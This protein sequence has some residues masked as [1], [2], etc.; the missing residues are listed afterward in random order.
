MS[1][2]ERNNKPDDKVTNISEEKKL[3]N[4]VEVVVKKKIIPLINYKINPLLSSSILNYLAIGINLAI[5]GCVKKEFFKLHLHKEFYSKYYLVSGIFLYI[6]GL[7]DWYDGKEL[8]YLVDFILSFFFVSLFFFENRN[9]ELNCFKFFKIFNE[10]GENE[11]LHGTFYILLFLFFFCIAIS[12]KN[13]G[14]FYIVDH[15]SLF[16]GFIFLFLHKYFDKTWL[17][18]T[19]SYIFIISGGLFWLTGLLKM[20]DNFLIN[21]SLIFLYPSD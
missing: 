12:Y 3:K 7:F 5:F 15:A 8:L 21:N 4:D 17:L 9:E 11:K 20:I 13:K 6:S 14:K 19:Y 2:E 1:S 16:I 18:E 10:V